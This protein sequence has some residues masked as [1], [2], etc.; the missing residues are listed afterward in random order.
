[1]SDSAS[2]LPPE[3]PPV[4]GPGLLRVSLRPSIWRRA[5]LE[6]RR[7]LELL[8]HEMQTASG[9]DLQIPAPSDGWEIRLGLTAEHLIVALVDGQGL[10]FDNRSIMLEPLRGIIRTYLSL[11]ARMGGSISSHSMGHFEALDMARRATHNEASQ[12]VQEALE[13]MLQVDL[14]AAR[15]LFT[16]LCLVYDT[17]SR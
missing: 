17:P 12:R 2:E 4:T 7:E 8:L 11:I 6:R 3:Q 1:M 13:G 10:P 14:E 16:I 15:R 9:F 5:D